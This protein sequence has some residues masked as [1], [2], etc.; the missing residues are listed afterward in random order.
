M[1]PGPMPT[2]TEV[3]DALNAKKKKDP[4]YKTNRSSRRTEKHDEKSHRGDEKRYTADSVARFRRIQREEK[5]TRRVQRSRLRKKE[6]DEAR[7][8][9]KPV[10]YSGEKNK[11]PFV[12]KRSLKLKK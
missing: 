5:V 10:V 9:G 8:A 2:E 3:K 11:K 7:A 12:S 6:R 4:V 1:S